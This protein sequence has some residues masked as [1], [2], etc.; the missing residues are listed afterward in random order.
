MV[1]KRKLG[2]IMVSCSPS[3]DYN[4]TH[5]QTKIPGLHASISF[6]AFLEEALF[7]PLYSDTE[8]IEKSF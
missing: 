4:D 8:A 5:N 7:T 2:K 3:L 6:K 1:Q